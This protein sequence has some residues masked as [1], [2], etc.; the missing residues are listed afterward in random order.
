MRKRK[1]Q[2]VK[3]LIQ[4]AAVIAAGVLAIILFMLAIWYRGKN[5][6][7]VT[8]EQVAAQM[9]QAEPLVIETPFTYAKTGETTGKGVFTIVE[10]KA[11]QGASA[12]WGRLKSGAGW[13][14]L[15]YATRLA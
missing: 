9:Q 7:P 11:G 8:D 13:I 1:R 4:C 3:K 14:S 5:S 6:E 15:D 2:A 10:V 12:G